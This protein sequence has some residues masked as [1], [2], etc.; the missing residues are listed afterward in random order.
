M[1][2]ILHRRKRPEIHPHL[3]MEAL[4]AATLAGLSRAI[5]SPLHDDRWKIPFDNHTNGRHQCETTPRA[6]L[7]IAS[8]YRRTEIPAWAASATSALR[9]SHATLKV[10]GEANSGCV[11]TM[12]ATV[13][14]KIY[15]HRTRLARATP[16]G[17]FHLSR[18]SLHHRPRRSWPRLLFAAISALSNR[19]QFPHN[20][21]SI[22]PLSPNSRRST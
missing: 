14:S 2:S 7:P 5:G 21:P 17:P 8:E 15:H 16:P 10:C 1:L 11:V 6:R 9:K 22:T 19:F 3:V 13:A 18:Q 4:P 12:P 20:R